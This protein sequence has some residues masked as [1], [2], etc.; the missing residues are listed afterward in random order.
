M[1]CLNL[2][3]YGTMGILEIIKITK[4]LPFAVVFEKNLEN[5]KCLYFDIIMGY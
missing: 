5:K 2:T 3:L 1:K 4:L